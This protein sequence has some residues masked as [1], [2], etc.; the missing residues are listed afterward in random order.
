MS[1]DLKYNQAKQY[2][3]CPNITCDKIGSK[4]CARCCVAYYC[5]K[6]C[7]VEDWKRHKTTCFPPG[8]GPSNHSNSVDNG[9]PTKEQIQAVIPKLKALTRGEAEYFCT[10]CGEPGLCVKSFIKTCPDRPGKTG[11]ALFLCQKMHQTVNTD[12]TMGEEIECKCTEDKPT[13]ILTDHPELFKKQFEYPYVYPTSPRVL[14]LT[15]FLFRDHHGPYTEKLSRKLTAQS[16]PFDIMNTNADGSN[17]VL[18]M[19]SGKYSKVV[20]VHLNDSVAIK[21]KEMFKKWLSF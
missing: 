12:A 2:K 13:Q 8:Q 9:P 18:A 19:K 20:I 11:S 10:T 17:A 7:Q 14:I 6:E 4:K 15:G 16:L 1:F 5:S 21:L 3:T